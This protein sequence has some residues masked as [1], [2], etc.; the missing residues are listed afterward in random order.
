MSNADEDIDAAEIDSWITELNSRPSIGDPRNR[1]IPIDDSIKQKSKTKKKKEARP[2][3]M[4]TLHEH[5]AQI[6][7]PSTLMDLSGAPSSDSEDGSQ[8]EDHTVHEALPAKIGGKPKPPINFERFHSQA[9]DL[10][11]ILRLDDIR[12][13]GAPSRVPNSL[14]E[15]SSYPKLQDPCVQL[16]APCDPCTASLHCTYQPQRLHLQTDEYFS[17]RKYEQP[18]D[19]H[20][21]APA[22][23]RLQ[24]APCGPP[25]RTR[26]SHSPPPTIITNDQQPPQCGSESDAPETPP[27]A[28]RPPGAAITIVQQLPRPSG[29]THPPLS[30]PR[31]G[32]G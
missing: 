1:N 29:Q 25:G 14:P 3:G 18:V 10:R 30:S 21:N 4:S 17:S 20:V 8:L 22:T 16:P 31:E 6:S 7:S 26:P 24:T 27:L 15:N 2:S 32:I 19:D 23:F 9:S 5:F 11:R 13:E 12:I 28:R